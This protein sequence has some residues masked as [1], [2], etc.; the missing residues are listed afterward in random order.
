MKNHLQ[1]ACPHCHSLNR[2]PVAR[3]NDRP[4][5]GQCHA[6]LFTGQP[7]TLTSGSFD[8]HASRSDI[9]LAVDFWASW[10]GPC[11]VMAP[12]FQEAAKI[13][14][15]D[16]RLGKVNSEAERSL[17]ARFRIASIPTLIVLREG[18]ELARQ[19]GVM[20]TQDIVR[21]V[22]LHAQDS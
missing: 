18:R 9:P 19:S 13:L 1:V 16:V 6:P 8:L 21:W 11:Q 4:K 14:E 12:S 7:L 15:P 10:C 17:A 22:R 20:G 2:V 5:C 3:V